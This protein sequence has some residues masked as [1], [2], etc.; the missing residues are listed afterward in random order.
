MELCKISVAFS[1]VVLALFSRMGTHGSIG[2][3]QPG[4][5]GQSNVTVA[6]APNPASAENGSS[7]QDFLNVHNAA[8]AAVGVRPIT[9]N[10][11]VARYAAD[12]AEKRI[13]DCELVHSGGHYGENFAWSSGDLS[14]S[15]AVRMW[16]NENINYNLKSGVCDS[17]R[18]CRQYAQVIWRNA[19]SLGC[20]K[21]RCNNGGTFVICNY[22]PPSNIVGK[23]PIDV[24]QSISRAISPSAAPAPYFFPSEHPKRK[25]MGGLVVGLIVRAC[26]L[27]FGLGLFL[28]FFSRTKRHKDDINIDN[29]DHISDAF[30]S[31]GEFRYGM[32]PR[33]FSLV[34]LAK[35]T[36]NFKGE[37]LGEGG[38]GAVYRGHLRDLDTNVAVKR[39][40][41]ASKQG[42]KEYAS[43]LRG[44]IISRLR[45]KNLVKLI[46]WCHEKR[47]LLLVYEFMAN[48][49]LDS[50][51]FKGKSLLNW[52][53]RYKIVQDLASALLY[54]HEEGDHCVLHRDIKTS[55]IMLNSNFNAKLGD[56]GLA[57]LVDHAKGSQTTRLAGTM[58]YMAPECVSSGKVSKESDV[59]SF[60]IVALE[61]ACGRRS[62]E[63]EYE[64]SK[65]S[66]VAWVWDSYGN[67]RLLD[68]ADQKLC[69]VFD[70]KQ[71]ECLLIVGLWCV[72]P[73]PSSR[74]SIR[75]AIQVLNFEAPL[76]ELP[77]SRPIPTYHAPIA[78]GVKA[79]EP[80]FSS[81]TITVPR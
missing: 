24:N 78:S 65:A 4:S 77:G 71:I 36:N 19:V 16:I 70:D 30:F 5:T 45:H 18:I 64:E 41:K 54:L 43:V 35:V 49:S 11:V 52:E 56:F 6:A 21:A 2:A 62:I 31:G 33:K 73:D 53:V 55:N 80:C 13:S 81:L 74:P 15:D 37:K 22:D 40:S 17:N 29:H 38:F 51:L 32:A 39:I 8:R 1:L 23:L 59:Y 27:I 61:I 20:A 69:M 12:Y 34:E 76:P 14:G 75:Q 9:W 58:G 63:P 47:E 25:D 57:R 68:V 28:W 46:G 48:G 7:P 44:S 3:T 79:S 67:Q 26:A 72:H 10:T 50:H 60:G 42:I 66:L